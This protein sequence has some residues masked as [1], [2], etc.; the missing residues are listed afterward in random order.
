M[1]KITR[2]EYDKLPA[3]GQTACPDCGLKLTTPF[4]NCSCPTQVGGWTLHINLYHHNCNEAWNRAYP[5]NKKNI[6]HG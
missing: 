5:T 1:G 4:P 3:N 2:E 6:G